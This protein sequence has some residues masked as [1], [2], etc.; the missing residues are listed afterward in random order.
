MNA[1]QSI[2]MTEEELEQLE[3][4]LVSDEVPAD[5]MNLEMLD[6]YLA[7][8]VSSPLPIPME[9]WLPAVWTADEGE[10][11]FGSGASLQKAIELV[12]RYYNELVQMIADQEGD[13]EGEAEGW[14]PFCYAQGGDDDP[15]IGEEWTAGFQQGFELWPAE[16]SDS[17][18][19]T[20][21]AESLLETILGEEEEVASPA[22]AEAQLAEL[23][24]KGIAV[25]HLYQ[26]W[27]ALG[28]PAPDPVVVSGA[29]AATSG[30]GRNEPCPCGSGKK[31]KKCCGASV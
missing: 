24:Q 1:P 12:L 30:P 31:Y 23:E 25:Q 26:N 29:V 9:Q 22:D 19:E 6:G 11:G 20:A 5:C 27:R 16:W 21:I 8:I 14:Q 7:A 15:A 3:D 4:L 10:V 13:E 2:P 28:L 17:V 18:P